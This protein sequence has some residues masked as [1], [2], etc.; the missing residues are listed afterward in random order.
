[1]TCGDPGHDYTDHLVE[2][3][4]VAEIAERLEVKVTTVYQWR[5]RKLLPE[6]DYPLGMGPAWKWSTIEEWARET[7][8]LTR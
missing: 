3:V 6:P 4:G 5:Q 2:V 8:R 7:R 1:M